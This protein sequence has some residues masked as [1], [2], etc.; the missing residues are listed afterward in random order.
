MPVHDWQKVSTGI[1]HDF[2]NVWIAELRTALNTGILPSDYYALSEQVA[3]DTGPDVLTLQARQENGR[4]RQP[5]PGGLATIT[6]KP[7]K[8]RIIQRIENGVYV[9][10]RKTLVIRHSSDDRVIAM[11]EIMS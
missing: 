6:T 5:N 1:F 8:V 4:S 7:P 9:R 2:H 3:G 11:I 10:K